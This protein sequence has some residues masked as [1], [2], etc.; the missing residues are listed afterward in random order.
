MSLYDSLEKI[1]QFLETERAKDIAVMAIIILVGLGSFGLGRLSE[2]EVKEGL[3]IGYYGPETGSEALKGQ[4]QG[5]D[6]GNRSLAQNAQKSA[7]K[8][9]FASNRGTKYYTLSCSAGKTIKEENRVYYETS[10]EAEKAGYTLSSSC[11]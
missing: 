10:T 9:F 7:I 3:K 8:N 6:L 4:N 1:K 2:K 5:L 11:K